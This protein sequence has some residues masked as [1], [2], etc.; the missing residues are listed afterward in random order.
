M[1]LQQPVRTG[2]RWALALSFCLVG[3]IAQSSQAAPGAFELL[4]PAHDSE[5][6]DVWPWIEWEAAADTCDVTYTLKIGTSATFAPGTYD[7]Y[8]GLTTTLFKPERD[9]RMETVYYWIVTA[10][11]EWGEE[12]LASTPENSWFDY[13]QFQTIDRSIPR[14]V[15]NSEPLISN[16]TIIAYNTPYTMV[17]G[18]LDIP[19]DKWFEIEAGTRLEIDGYY[20]F[21][22][23]GELRM[24]GSETNMITVTSAADSP[25]S[26]DWSQVHFADDMASSVMDPDGYWIS[27]STLQY[28]HFEYAGSTTYTIYSN[29]PAIHIQGCV[30]DNCSNKGGIQID[31]ENCSLIGNTIE[32]YSNGN[33]YGA[34]LNCQGTGHIVRSNVVRD[35]QAYHEI[36][37]FWGTATTSAYGGG[38]YLVGQGH[39]VEENVFLNCQA[40]SISRKHN[41]LYEDADLYAYSY[42]GGVYLDV[43]SSVIANNEIVNC[44]SVATTSGLES[45]IGTAESIEYGGGIYIAGTGTQ[46]VWEDNVTSGNDASFGGGVFVASS[47]VTLRR[48]TVTNNHAD[49]NGGGVYVENPYFKLFDSIVKYNLV[50]AS[51][52]AGGIYAMADSICFNNIN[53]NEGH[54]LMVN[55]AEDIVATENWWYTRRD[56]DVIR[57]AIWDQDDTEGALGLVTYD[58]YLRDVSETTPN[59]F[60][61][62]TGIQPHNDS[63]YDSPLAHTLAVGDTVYFTITGVDSNPYNRDVAVAD[64]VNLNQGITASPFFEET[65]DNTGIFQGRGILSTVLSLPDSLRVAP[66]DSVIV[67]ASI[68]IEYRFGFRVDTPTPPV[69]DFVADPTIAAVGDTIH[70]S[71]QSSGGVIGYEWDFGDLATSTETSPNHVY[72]ASG[73]YDVRL[74]AFGNA[75]NDTMTSTVTI[76]GDHPLVTAA[77]DVPNDQGGRLQVTFTRST[78]D[79]DTLVLPEKA[80]EIYTVERLDGLDWTTVGSAAAYGQTQYTVEVAT[81]A[82]GVETTFRVIAAMDEGDYASAEFVG[83]STDDLVP[84]I[85]LIAGSTGGSVLNWEAPTDTPDL[86]YYKVYESTAGELD[87]NQQWLTDTVDTQFDYS[88][89]SLQFLLITAVDFS[90]NEGEPAVFNRAGT[91][92][93]SLGDVTTLTVTRNHPNP[94]NP[95]TVIDY[96]LPRSGHVRVQIFDIAGRRVTTLADESQ[97]AGWHQAIWHGEDASGA[98]VASGTY[99]CRIESG[100]EV[101][102]QRMALIK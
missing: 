11:N 31:C 88:A 98:K 35:C 71:N 83:I 68:A 40:Q 39:L 51:G 25:A 7:E 2:A 61:I 27:G 15:T 47:D 21:E 80:A 48:F 99:F 64:M 28:V 18:D 55:G 50:D 22:V 29:A 85:P 56:V 96:G 82:D 8:S 44:S 100:G 90:G 32:G 43:S 102:T 26:G 54:Q 73:T 30:L 97:T 84:G 77:A 69:A 23:H 58:P 4:Q 38:L 17:Q 53:H 34:G 9:L 14:Y 62:V 37:V 86:K 65:G 59:R 20:G 46:N 95:T 79:T 94:F 66:G 76:I 12:T 78:A 57:E 16:R 81:L 1:I 89:A 49:Q 75:V 41:Y 93:P 33:R 92:L 6:K 52:M 67:A 74:V 101:Q 3:L 63:G 5:S 24:L 19:A 42:G 10:V 87:G 72:A 60:E 91:G 70:F 36:S 13:Y 45:Q